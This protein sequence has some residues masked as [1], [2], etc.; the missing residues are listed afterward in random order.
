MASTRI[1]PDITYKRP[2]GGGDQL[3]SSGRDQTVHMIHITYPSRIAVNKR[4]TKKYV[5]VAEV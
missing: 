2:R 1:L 5:F 4:E 3:Q